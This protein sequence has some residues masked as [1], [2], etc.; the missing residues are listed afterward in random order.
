MTAGKS[1]KEQNA[2]LIR[3]ALV[4]QA[5]AFAYVVFEP[6]PIIQFTEPGVARKLQDFLAPGSISLGLI[7]LTRLVLLGLIPAQ[8]RDRLIHWR[9]SHP[10]PGARAF[11]KI[12]PPE[13]R[14]DMSK[15]QKKYGPLPTDP[16]EQNRLF[17]SVY[18]KQADDVGVLDAH[19]SY[20]A[21][22]D[23]GT[24]NLLLLILLLPLAGW[25]VQSGKTVAIYGV[26]L[27]SAYVV[28]CVAAQVYG[29][30]LVQNSLAAASRRTN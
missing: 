19:K 23:L 25:F 28:M 26:F 24:I 11:T 29:T 14:V 15:L 22:R 4:V 1:L 27:V 13:P 16:A 18:R 8:L 17:Y 30:R 3:T 9:W 6:F 10:L 21:A 2:W 20:L 7:A 12:G 5:A